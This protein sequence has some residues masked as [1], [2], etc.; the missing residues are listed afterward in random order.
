MSS[1]LETQ[2]PIPADADRPS[3]TPLRSAVLQRALA[4]FTYRDFRVLWF[5]AFTSTVGTW[6]QKVAQSWLVF[7][8]TRSSF[9]LGLDDFLGQLPILLLTLI[10]GVIADRHD[11]RHLLLGSQFV[12]MLTAFTLAALVYA[13]R[14]SIWHILAL[15]FSAGVAQAFGGPAYQALIPSLVARKDLPNAIA[16]NSIQ[17]NL[18][19]VFGPLFAGVTIAALGAAG[20]F[21]LNGLSFLVVI[22]ALMSLSVTHIPPT[23]RQPMIQELKGGLSYAR[24]ETAIVALT[25]LAFMTTFLGLPLVT[26]LPVF[27]RQIFHGDIAAYSE[28]MACSGIGAVVGALIV[29]WLGRFRHMGLALLAVQAAFGGLI[30]AFAVSRVFWLSNLLLFFSGAAL[31]V[32]FSMTASLVQLIV[33]DHL[34]GRVMSIYMVAFRG[35]MPLGSLLSGYAASLTSTPLVLGV[36]GALV[37]VVAIYFV[38]RSRGVR[39]L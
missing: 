16:L 29:A 23:G 27:A 8:M 4:A 7:E 12:Q 13:D 21:G 2:A 32:V 3:S 31:I 5:G 1:P 6:M 36:N 26:F 14:V 18:A 17:F 24:S 33:P 28:M 35:G 37:S 10:G 9:Y 30:V 34:R 19:R 22:I 38:V 20:C 39:E 15:S 25:V 11:R